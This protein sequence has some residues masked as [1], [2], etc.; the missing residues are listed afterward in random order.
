LCVWKSNCSLLIIRILESE[1][2]EASN[3]LRHMFDDNSLEFMK[4]R[5]IFS[6][7]HTIFHMYIVSHLSSTW[8]FLTEHLEDEKS[9]QRDSLIFC[10]H[11]R[12]SSGKVHRQLWVDRD[13]YPKAFFDNTSSFIFK[14]LAVR[15]NAPT[16]FDD[17]FFV[18][19]FCCF[20]FHPIESSQ[21][22]APIRL[23]D[24]MLSF[25]FSHLKQLPQ[26]E[27]LVFYAN[28]I[29]NPHAP[30]VLTYFDANK[31]RLPLFRMED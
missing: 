19:I 30:S 14:H 27:R 24:R 29:K 31:V 4:L 9:P 13:I 18:P 8:T 22:R 23:N 20:E 10:W 7:T 15:L 28:F 3:F 25:Y 17:L 11:L 1:L 16:V 6:H 5:I 26:N 21:V 12:E 2:K